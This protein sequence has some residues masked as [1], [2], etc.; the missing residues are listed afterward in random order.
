MSM[1]EADNLSLVYPYGKQALDAIH[2]HLEAGALLCLCGVN[3]SGKSSLFSLLSGIQRP[4]SGSLR[5]GEYTSPGNEA[6][7][8]QVTAMLLQDADMQMIGGTVGED[9]TLTLSP[10]DIE[11]WQRAQNL[12]E[13]FGLA[14]YWN[15]PVH[16]LSYG[17]KRKVCLAGALLDNPQVLLLDEPF[18]GLDYPA[19]L[20]LRQIL[21]EQK[22][23]GLTQIVSVHDLEPVLD[24]ADRMLVLHQGQQVLYGTPESILDDA[25]QYG[26]RPP[27]SWKAGLGILPYE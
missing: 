1:I 19:I 4:S 9:C 12:V 10:D 13:R 25:Q 23:M 2:F 3:G 11:G 5:V 7:L 21:I 22:R 24:L 20:E 18:S 26:V 17:Q 14:G 15:H 6:A 8:R 27:C 16:T